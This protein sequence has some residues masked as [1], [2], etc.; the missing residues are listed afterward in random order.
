MVIAKFHSW[1]NPYENFYWAVLTYW[2]ENR[3]YIL[4]RSSAAKTQF[5]ATPA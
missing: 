4:L 2:L 1:E 3:Q 5:L